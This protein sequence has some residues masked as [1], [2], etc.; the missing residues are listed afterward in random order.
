MRVLVKRATGALAALLALAGCGG[1]G[2]GSA[3]RAGPPTVDVYSSLPLLGPSSSQGAA[4]LNGI[5]L[6]LAQA[7]GRAGRWTVDYKS[8]DDS[9]A[10]S[11]GWDP[12]QT[13]ANAQK[14]ASDPKAVL[15]IGELDSDASAVSIPVLNE[16]GIAQISPASTYA[17]L[18]TALPGAASGEPMKYDPTGTPTFLRLA[19]IDSIQGAADLIAM[20]QAG[21]QNVAV[22]DDGGLYG[23]GLAALLQLEKS[24]YGVTIA[25]STTV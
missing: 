13:E 5:K 16:A 18:T 21:C 12:G 17:G 9:S 14:A 15:Y 6:A 4:I 22:A 20:K 23:S 24:R 8:L 1:T 19:P 7:N 10:A 3:D 11:G 25:A 2:A